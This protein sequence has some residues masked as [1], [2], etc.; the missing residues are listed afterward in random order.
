MSEHENRNKIIEISIP[1]SAT[2]GKTIDSN[3]EKEIEKKIMKK[4]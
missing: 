2:I 3:Y 4:I 1:S